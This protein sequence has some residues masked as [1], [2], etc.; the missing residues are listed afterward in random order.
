MTLSQ[1]QFIF[2][3]AIIDRDADAI[4]QSGVLTLRSESDIAVYQNAY[5]TRLRDALYSHYPILAKYLDA[6]DFRVLVNSYIEQHKSHTVSLRDYGEQLAA[7]CRSH[8]SGV[9]SAIAAE[10][11][12]FEWRLAQAF[13]ALE[14]VAATV[15]QL[16]A[17]D[18]TLWPGLRFTSVPSLQLHVST[19][20]AITIWQQLH[21]S[22]PLGHR[23]AAAITALNQASEQSPT[24]WVISRTGLD[25][26]FRSIPQDEAIA[27]ESLLSGRNFADLCEQLAERHDAVAPTIAATYLK[28]WIEAGWLEKV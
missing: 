13:D 25:I 23:Q 22:S 2:Q 11:A 27:L 10:L 8:L 3:Q 9:R 1:L 28:A 4:R 5:R 18:P 19:T 26:C 15:S 16:S 21:E 24:H 12:L 7:H 17:L 14:G 6:E 20:P